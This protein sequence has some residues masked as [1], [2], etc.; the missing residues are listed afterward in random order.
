MNSGDRAD[1]WDMGLQSGRGVL[2][3]VV[4]IV[5]IVV[6][7]ALLLVPSRSHGPAARATSVAAAPRATPALS[8]PVKL[9][10]L[11]GSSFTT[12]YTA[13]WHL[14][15]RQNRTGTAAIYKLSSTG[16]EPNNLGIPPAGTVGITIVE[17]PASLLAS[18][19]LLGAP[20]DTA[21]ATQSTVQLLAHVV[22]TPGGAQGITL[23]DPPARSSLGGAEAG[24]ESYVYTYRG[25]GDVQVNILSHH[26]QR[27]ATIELN[28]EPTLATQGQAELEVIGHHW[29]WH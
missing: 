2:V 9:T 11:R 18:A 29:R 3:A 10:T 22:G 19:H 17:Y 1:G 16:S 12:S 28:T 14:S 13:G 5:G 23:A 4:V 20:T 8:A 6:G 24:V 21:T 7:A 27:V 25:V 26:K 15:S